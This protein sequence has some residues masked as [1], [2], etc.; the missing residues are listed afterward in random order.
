MSEITNVPVGI[1]T[2]SPIGS[3]ED[4]YSRIIAQLPPWFGADPNLILDII[5]EAFV[6][7]GTFHYTQYG[8]AKLQT[9]IATATDINLDNI[10]KDYLGDELP[11]RINESDELY[12][13]RILATLLREKCT[14]RG[15]RLAI[16]NLTGIEPIIF[17]PWNPSDCGGYNVVTNLAYNTA[18][19][20]GSGSFAYQGFIDVFVD[21]FTGMSNYSGFNN[22]FGGYNAYGGLAT[23]WY[24]GESINTNIITDS[25]I[26]TLINLTKVYGTVVW[27]RIHRVNL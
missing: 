22:Y 17:E 27:V 7:T 23:F 11:R 26:Y 16:L 5:I 6:N 12:R 10:S 13:A 2:G 9:R 4:V 1:Q 18:G 21:S 14:R 25:D 19:R 3:H 8:Y 15:L 24:G 20:Y